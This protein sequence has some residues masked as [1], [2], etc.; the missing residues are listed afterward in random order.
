MI[1]HPL[2]EEKIAWEHRGSGSATLSQ[3]DLYTQEDSKVVLEAKIEPQE[4][5]L[6]AESIEEEE[7]WANQKKWMVMCMEKARE[8]G[9]RY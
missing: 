4:A 8:R 3:D 5:V 9:L 6:E 7:Y 2:T 1:L